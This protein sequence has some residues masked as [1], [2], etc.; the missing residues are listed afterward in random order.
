[1]ADK[2]IR[3]KGNQKALMELLKDGKPHSKREIV[4]VVDGD[5][6]YISQWVFRIRKK[7]NPRG[8][9]I[10]CTY[11]GRQLKYQLVRLISTK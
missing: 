11:N 1:M 10:V 5:I 7:I 9:E 3:F 8:F 2:P 6:K 4:E